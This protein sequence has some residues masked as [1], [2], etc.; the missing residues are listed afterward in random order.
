MPETDRLGNI[1]E[2]Q[3]MSR[4]D[5]DFK[6]VRNP[7]DYRDIYGKYYDPEVWV[8]VGKVQDQTVR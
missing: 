2:R 7:A 1:W 6:P 8:I 3:R 5:P 4:L